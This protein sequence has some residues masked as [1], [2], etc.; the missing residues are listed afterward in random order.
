M[1]LGEKIKAFREWKGWSIKKLAGA[2]KVSQQMLSKIEKG[3]EEI[4]HATLEKIKGSGIFEGELEDMKEMLYVEEAKEE[5]EDI[6]LLIKKI[7]SLDEIGKRI[8]AI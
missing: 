5:K 3:E 2:G 4:E 7:A 6:S 1:P 8:R